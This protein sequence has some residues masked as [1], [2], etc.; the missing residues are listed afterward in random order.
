MWLNPHLLDISFEL[1]N[2]GRLDALHET[3]RLDWTLKHYR[4]RQMSRKTVLLGHIWL[5]YRI[6]TQ[7]Q[8]FI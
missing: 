6:K 7:F 2:K 5:L 4:D 8:P 3:N 1:S